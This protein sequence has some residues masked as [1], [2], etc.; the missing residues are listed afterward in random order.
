MGT[1]VI[2]NLIKRIS[3]ENHPVIQLRPGQIFQGKITQLYPG[4][5]AQMQLGQ[6]TMTAHL[7]AQLEKGERYWFKVTSSE[8]LPRL[9]VLDAN[10]KNVTNAGHVLQQ[11]GIHQGAAQVKLT[12]YMIDK[13]IPFTRHNINEASPL[14]QQSP[15]PQKDTLQLLSSMMQ[16]QVP[17]SRETFQALASLQTNQPLAETMNQLASELRVLP[18]Q[19]QISEVRQILSQLLS[20]PHPSG[21]SS[22][23][24]NLLHQ[25]LNGSHAVKN[26]AG[27]MMQ[28]LDITK[29]A[30]VKEIV[31]FI[32]RE[33]ERP[34]NAGIVRQLLPEAAATAQ[35]F[36]NLQQM[37]AQQILQ[38]FKLDSHQSS[39][40]LLQLLSAN[41]PQEVQQKLMQFVKEPPPIAV[42]ELWNAMQ[43]SNSHL[44]SSAGKRAGAEEQPLRT[45]LQQLGM[46]HENFI[47]QTFRQELIFPNKGAEQAANLKSSL[48]NLLQMQQ[49]PAGIRDQAE[50]L[51]NRIT[52][53]QII[54]QE[55]Q[56]PL[57]H[58][59]VQVP[60][61][62]MQKYQDMTI[63]WTGKETKDGK[64]SEDHCRILFYLH[65]DTLKETIVDVQI[66]NRIVSVNIFNEYNKPA[67]ASATWAPVLKEALGALNYQLS[68]IN[69]KQPEAAASKTAAASVYKMPE[70]YKGVDFRV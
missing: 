59:L 67:S 9:K 38:Q 27:L 16:R 61:L 29:S 28:Q 31:Q 15:L 46:Q 17:V 63:Q 53:Y 51:L 69:W 12:Q 55:Q 45:F 7:E 70:F 54:S 58:F 42:K 48:L 30:G 26:Q 64:L 14:L 52:G 6:M 19:R 2:H 44:N 41:Q 10:A 24:G 3:T 23:L 50:F 4:A 20:Q 37:T 21:G 39:R 57:Q 65:L 33:I 11:L 18:Q 13:N 34:E 40:P 68:S 56:G 47:R 32:Q 5:S 35:S 43:P 25:L 8:G 60:L 49:L 62:T 1:N 36:Q 22:P 66:Q